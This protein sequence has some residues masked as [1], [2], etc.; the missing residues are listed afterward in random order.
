MEGASKVSTGFPEVSSET[1]S[2]L[3]QGGQSMSQFKGTKTV[4]NRSTDS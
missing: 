1:L 4:M 3:Y 2:R